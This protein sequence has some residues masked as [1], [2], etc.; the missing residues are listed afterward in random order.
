MDVPSP[1][2]PAVPVRDLAPASRRLLRR[3]FEEGQNRH[4]ELDLS[5][6][7]YAHDVLAMI[8]T[9]RSAL[10][11]PVTPSRIE[12]A[13]PKRAL[14][15]LYL[16]RACEAGSERAWEVLVATYESRLIALAAREGGRRA[17]PEQA[18]SAL[19]AELALP[20]ARGGAR[21]HIGTFAGMGALGAWLATNLVRRVWNAERTRQRQRGTATA[22]TTSLEEPVWAGEVARDA[23]DQL[24]TA[25]DAGW[26][27]LTKE[28]RLCFLL[29]HRHG[30]KQRRV[31]ALLGTAE[32]QVSR[33]IRRATLKIR[34]AIDHGVSPPDEGEHTA[35]DHIKAT[36][37][38]KLAT[39]EA[40]ETPSPES[41]R[42]TDD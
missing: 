25:L 24:R 15:D 18:V 21:T 3:G 26:R 1:R 28:E 41:R 32:Y 30:M 20:A 34:G 33:H 38:E 13:L 14:S 8:R 36:L 17:G 19:F 29:K 5:F 40:L 35:W 37:A 22:D 12:A 9:A 39:F 42:K 10:G 4:G 27:T 11:L 6:D 23:A 31:A 2:S 16:A 7:T